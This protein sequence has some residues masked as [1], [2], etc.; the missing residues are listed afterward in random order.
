MVNCLLFSLNCHILCF[1][2]LYK[3]FSF[4]KKYS[5]NL[6]KTGN[7]LQ[8]LEWKFS[9]KR[10]FL[11]FRTVFNIILSTL[12]TFY[13]FKC[14][15]SYILISEQFMSTSHFSITYLIY[16]FFIF[17]GTS[18]ICMDIKTVVIKTF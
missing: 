5:D 13:S 11:I 6:S 4:L 8:F 14:I 10:L 9:K 15:F 3:S 1:P 18:V 16:L 12:S 17:I 2:N 7:I